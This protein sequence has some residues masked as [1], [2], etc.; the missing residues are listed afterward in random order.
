MGVAEV[1][2]VKQLDRIVRAL[3]NAGTADDEV[4]KPVAIDVETSLDKSTTHGRWLI[5]EI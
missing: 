3:R 5:L 1:R 2:R 4:G